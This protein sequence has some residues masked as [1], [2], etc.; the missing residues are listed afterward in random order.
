MGCAYQR[1]A[2]AK[3]RCITGLPAFAGAVSSAGTATGNQR[4]RIST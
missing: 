4:L 1:S 2:V 3:N